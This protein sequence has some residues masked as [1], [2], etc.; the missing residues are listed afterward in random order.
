MDIF[1]ALHKTIVTTANDY[2]LNQLMNLVKHVDCSGDLR[3]TYDKSL[4]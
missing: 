1:S 2:F 3:I 4:S